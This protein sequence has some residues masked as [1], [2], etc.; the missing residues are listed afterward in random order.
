MRRPLPFVA[1]LGFCGA[2]LGL[3]CVGDD[4]GNTNPEND[5]G[6]VPT[7][8]G[9]T[10][11][12]DA[13]TTPENDS[14]TADVGPPPPCK[15]NEPFATPKPFEALNSDEDDGSVRFSA[16]GTTAYF[17]RGDFNVDADIFV[18]K[19]PTFAN[20]V[21]LAGVN[22]TFNAGAAPTISRASAPTGSRSSST[23]PTDWPMRESSARRE[24]S[25]RKILVVATACPDSKV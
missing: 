3:A 7:Q 19:G 4:P 23:R 9:S 2:V 21:R 25:T 17:S 14:G 10:E 20:P 11:D 8:D 13:A 1:V 12:T 15:L 6:K 22:S 18:A 16:D 24:R 5:G